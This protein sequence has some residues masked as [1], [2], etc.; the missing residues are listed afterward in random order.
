MGNNSLLNY[1]S[2]F[3][4][5]ILKK[6]NFLLPRLMGL[7]ALFK[8][9]TVS[10][11][12]KNNQANISII[13]TYD[14]G[15]G[16]AKIAYQLLHNPAKPYRFQLFVKYKKSTNEH[17]TLLNELPMN[18]IT[19]WFLEMERFGDWLD[20]AKTNAFDL[21]SSDFYMQSSIIHLHNLH[22]GY[23]SYAALPALTS[24]KKVIWTL[25]DDHLLTGHCASSLN[26]ERWKHGCGQCPDLTIYPPIKND[27]TKNLFLE[28]QK[29]LKKIQPVIV[30][31]S[32]WLKQKIAFSH[33]FLKDVRVINNGVDIALYKPLN[34]R[35]IREKYHVKQDALVIVFAAELSLKNPFKG[36]K[37]V[38]ETFHA[39]KNKNVQ[40]ISIGSQ[41]EKISDNHIVFDYITN[42]SMLAELYALS[43]LLIY[44]SW[45]DNF[46]LVILE[47]MACGT[48]VIG[49]NVGGIPEIIQDKFNGY[50]ISD[51]K[52]HEKYVEKI[53][54]YM[55]LN[56]EEKNALSNNTRD[57]IVSN[58]RLEKMY[59][60]YNQ[61]YKEL[62]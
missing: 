47:A 8:M 40:F 46:P 44:P 61:L 27:N 2:V 30:C 33:P 34:K 19:R 25:H 32:E 20:F 56:T 60:K 3:T 10:T 9:K 13:N 35:E 23:F 29:M 58:Y 52:N 6:N 28:K 54:T 26:C 22:G 55:S 50:L 41:T 16:A 37:T 18:R 42:E 15:G 45:S 59:E 1:K 51:Y 48:P 12:R 5:Y 17:V 57:N 39:I 14:K 21:L 7:Y 62:A 4:L 31:P 24:S 53:K 11:K 36:G 49:S 38:I 43:D